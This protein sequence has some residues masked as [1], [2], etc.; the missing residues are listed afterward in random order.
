MKGVRERRVDM[1]L[2]RILVEIRVV[3]SAGVDNLP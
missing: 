2:V 1:R 3:A